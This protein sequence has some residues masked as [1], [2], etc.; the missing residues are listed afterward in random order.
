MT[1]NP[2]PLAPAPPAAFA[3]KTPADEKPWRAADAA[4]IS[5]L[6][7][8][9]EHRA[10]VEHLENDFRKD[11]TGDSTGLMLRTSLWASARWKALFVGAELLDARAFTSDATPLNTT[12]ANP[13]ELLQAV[14]ALRT[15][16][17]LAKGDAFSLT[18]GRMTLDVGMRRLAA[19]NEFRNTVNAFSGADL[20]W[21]SATGHHARAFVVVPVSRLPSDAEGLR[22]ARVEYDQENPSVLFWGSLFEAPR[23]RGDLHLEGYV[24]GLHERD[25]AEVP[26]A[27]RRLLTPG[28]RAW[29]P[30][31]EGRLDGQVEA[32]LQV[33]R[34]RASSKP[35]DARDLRHLAASVHASVGYRFV[36]PWQPRAALV[37]DEAT[38]DDSPNDGENHRFDPLFGARRFEFGPTGLYGAVARSNLRSPG[39]RLEVRPHARVDAF[40]A[41]RAVWL[42]SATDAWTT[43]GLRDSSGGSG[44]F[45][46]HQL[47]GRVRWQILP[48]NLAVEVGGAALARG[49]FA[50]TVPGHKDAAPLY[51]YVQLTATM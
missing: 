47:E 27:N 42:A 2:G 45:V 46:G 39:A 21:T 44:S 37:Y 11:A 16:D 51:G 17:L 33:G 24:L 36:A 35:E 19:R 49:R 18:A 48:R 40:A 28:V 1:A 25:S 31:A 13:L 6:R 50:T 32:M 38:G 26:S 29:R 41:Y 3:P 20:Q 34:S 12:I 22:A 8:G 14:V 7:F 5:W 30:P 9:L 4:G 15:T 43:S 23:L 10:R